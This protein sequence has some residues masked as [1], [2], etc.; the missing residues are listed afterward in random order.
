MKKELQAHCEEI[1]GKINDG[2]ILTAEDICCLSEPEMY[3]EGD[4]LSGWD[5]I[6]DAYNFRWLVDARDNVLECQIMVAGG[7]PEI[8]VHICDDGT[9]RV[10]GY[11]W[12]D[13]ATAQITDDAMGVF[14][15]AE[16]YYLTKG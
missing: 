15:A 1:A 7:G 13:R 8:W 4:M 16:E 6:E 2:I 12:G 14:E 10:E 9:G 11:W 5:Y 3:Q